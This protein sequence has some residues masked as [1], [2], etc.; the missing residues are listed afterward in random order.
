MGS[1]QFI[2]V[3]CRHSE[4]PQLF[5]LSLSLSIY[6]YIYAVFICLLLP[7][8]LCIAAFICNGMAG[9]VC[10]RCTQG[11]CCHR[12][13]QWDIKWSDALVCVFYPCLK[14]LFTPCSLSPHTGTR[15]HRCSVS[16]TL[17]TL[18][19]FYHSANLKYGC[20]WVRQQV[21]SDV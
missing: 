2:N 20:V 1:L 10:T 14:S 18:T 4:Q 3:I 17:C 5:L 19:H 7:L 6:L 15:T 16:H 13:H 12:R 21:F 8:P 9:C 11:L